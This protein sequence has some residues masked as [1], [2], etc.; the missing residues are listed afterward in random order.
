MGRSCAAVASSH[1]A[2][3]SARAQQACSLSTASRSAA[4][5]ETL[6]AGG[7][8]ATVL[9][10]L[11]SHRSKPAGLC[12]A[13]RAASTASPSARMAGCSRLSRRGPTI[14][15]WNYPVYLRFGKPL[16]HIAGGPTALAVRPDGS[17]IASG[18]SN[19]QIYLSIAVSQRCAAAC[20]E[21]GRSGQQHRFRP[22]RTDACGR[23][24]VT[25][26]S[27]VG[28]RDRQ[29]AGA[30]LRAQHA[31]RWNRSRLT[32]PVAR[33]VSGG[34]DGTV[35]LW[36]VRTHA[37][38]GRPLDGGFGAVYA[39]AFSPERLDGSRGR[40]RQSDPAVERANRDCRSAPRRSLQDDCRLQP[41][42]LSQRPRLASGGA[43]DTIHLWRIRASTPIA[44]STP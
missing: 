23:R 29:A 13:T 30:T 4:T 8:S 9:W 1:G 21:P 32:R 43:D 28:R 38:V 11:T 26:R 40:R 18:G 12:P 10:D 39:V 14:T 15:L 42:L 37:E 33:L 22:R 16:V 19:G 6:A 7:S 25:A 20:I 41:G 31:A 24:T 44:L 36:N 35:R 2:Q 27:A 17:V 34:S 5:A 3:I